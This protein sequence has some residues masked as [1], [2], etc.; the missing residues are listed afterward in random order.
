LNFEPGTL[1]KKPERRLLNAKLFNFKLFWK[2]P[3]TQHPAPSIRSPQ[4]DFVSLRFSFAGRFTPFPLTLF[5]YMAWSM[6]HGEKERY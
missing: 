3:S 1:N 5:W 2:L 6:G 4:A